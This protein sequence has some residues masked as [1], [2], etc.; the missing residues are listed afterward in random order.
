MNPSF[1]HYL[2]SI[3][4]GDLHFINLVLQLLLSFPLSS[5]IMLSMWAS[6]QLQQLKIFI[7]IDI[8]SHFHV[9]HVIVLEKLVGGLFILRA[10]NGNFR[11]YSFRGSLHN[12]ISVPRVRRFE[13]VTTWSWS[14]LQRSAIYIRPRKTTSLLLMQ[15]FTLHIG[16]FSHME[17]ASLE[18]NMLATSSVETY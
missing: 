17:L 12:E 3:E 14:P 15:V 7:E 6:L 4:G 9:Q 10:S 8:L 1:G 2:P 16:Q 13:L 18:W 5:R 11:L